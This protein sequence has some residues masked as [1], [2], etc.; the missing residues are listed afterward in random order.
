MAIGSYPAGMDEPCIT[1]AL[2]ATGDDED[3]MRF[4]LQ[5]I[6]KSSPPG[7]VGHWYC[8]ETT[9]QQEFH[10]K[11]KSYPAD[12]RYCVDSTFLRN[13]AD[14]VDVLRQAFTELPTRES[15]VLWNTMVPRSRRPLPDMALSLQS[16][17]YFAMYGV[18]EPD[19]DYEACEVWVRRNML[20]IGQHEVGAY[21]GEANPQVRDS[22]IWSAEARAR[23]LDIRRARDPQ[24][25]FSS[26]LKPRP[27][28]FRPEMRS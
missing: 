17:H 13:D 15:L 23:L 11:M 19:G 3:A 25:R 12:H 26:F 28:E 18:C 14:V 1:I 16:D 20:E 10:T 5:D 9:L 6:E 21:L 8:E 4:A 27:T 24:G 7:T 22:R 2:L